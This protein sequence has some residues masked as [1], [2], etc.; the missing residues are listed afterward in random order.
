MIFSVSELD[1]EKYI[2][3]LRCRIENRNELIEMH[4]K[5]IAA[6]EELR[7]IDRD[8]LCNLAIVKKTHFA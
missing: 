7:D 4:K 3:H 6:L 5:M 1:V 2:T 8:D